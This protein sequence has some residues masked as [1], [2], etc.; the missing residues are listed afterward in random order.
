MAGIWPQSSDCIALQTTPQQCDSIVP[1]GHE[2]V[3]GPGAVTV[4]I[5]EIA[6]PGGNEISAGGRPVCVYFAADLDADDTLQRDA[7]LMKTLGAAHR[8]LGCV[9]NNGLF[10]RH[11]AARIVVRFIEGEAYF[12]AC[13]TGTTL[14]TGVGSHR[15]AS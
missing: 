11:G 5:A 13:A 7:A 4:S 8:A 9:E 12:V 15:A 1:E 14:L 3:C 6:L 2:A 10:V